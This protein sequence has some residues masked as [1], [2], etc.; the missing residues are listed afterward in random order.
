MPDGATGLPLL[1]TLKTQIKPEPQSASKLEMIGKDY[2][3]STVGAQASLG[4]A[5]PRA[6]ETIH[7]WDVACQNGIGQ[8]G[9]ENLLEAKRRTNN[10][11]TVAIGGRRLWCCEIFYWHR[12]HSHAIAVAPLAANPLLRAVG[13]FGLPARQ[14]RIWLFYSFVCVWCG[15]GRGGVQPQPRVV[16]G[17]V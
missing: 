11:R 5:Q 7:W 3:F 1:C 16:W 14:K 8:D 10:F 15:H 4:C 2:R 13:C 12:C 17:W 9:S 6:R